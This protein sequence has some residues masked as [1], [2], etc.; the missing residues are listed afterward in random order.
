MP[1]ISGHSSP[2]LLLMAACPG[3]QLFTCL[4]STEGS[5]WDLAFHTPHSALVSSPL[6]VL[7]PPPSLWPPD[8]LCLRCYW[9]P[10]KLY[11]SSSYVVTLSSSSCHCCKQLHPSAVPYACS[12]P[13][14]TKL[15]G[16]C[17]LCY[18]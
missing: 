2:V 14:S 17:T 8:A 6:P 15:T 1:Q 5:L 18:L 7:P 13:K 16:L 3:L 10:E 11:L 12:L 4:D 9:P